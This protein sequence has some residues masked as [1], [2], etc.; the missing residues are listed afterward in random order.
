MSGLPT[1]EELKWK[2]ERIKA[3]EQQLRLKQN[4]A[5]PSPA[6]HEAAAKV[7]CNDPAKIHLLKQ[8]I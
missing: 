7:D 4:P 6:N 2:D 1:K 3:L 5:I 8:C